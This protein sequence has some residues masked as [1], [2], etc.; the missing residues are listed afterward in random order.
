LR[1]AKHGAV[2]IGGTRPSKRSPLSGS[3]A[4]T[5]LGSDHRLVSEVLE[6]IAAHNPD[7]FAAASDDPPLKP[8]AGERKPASAQPRGNGHD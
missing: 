4:E 3:S 7:L 2:T 1:I 5:R 8:S 6:S